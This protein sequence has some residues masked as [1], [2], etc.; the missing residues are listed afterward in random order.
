MGTEFTLVNLDFLTNENTEVVVI[1]PFFLEL[2][3]VG[4]LESAGFVIRTNDMSVTC[5][6]SVGETVSG[7]GVIGRRSIVTVLTLVTSFVTQFGLHSKPFSELITNI[8]LQRIFVVHFLAV[9]MVDGSDRVVERTKRLVVVQSGYL[10]LCK[11]LDRRISD[12]VTNAALGLRAGILRRIGTR[13]PN[14]SVGI[15]G[16]EAD[17]QVLNRFELRLEV[18]VITVVIRAVHDTFI[19]DAGIGEREVSQFVTA[20]EGE[21]MIAGQTM[22]TKGL[23]LPIGHF[24]GMPIVL[25][26]GNS[27][28]LV[29]VERLRIARVEIL[30]EVRRDIGGIAFRLMM[31]ILILHQ[32]EIIH[33][34]H[35]VFLSHLLPTH[36]AGIVKMELHLIVRV[37]VRIL[38]R[39]DDNTVS[40]LCTIDSGCG[41]ILENVHRLDVVRRDIRDRA[42]LE[43][44]NDVQRVAGLGK[45][46][47]T[48]NTDF[49]IRIGATFRRCDRYT[50]QFTLQCLGS[51]SHGN[52]LQLVCINRRNSGD[53]VTLLSR[54]ITGNDNFV[55]HLAVLRQHNIHHITSD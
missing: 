26:L 38:G 8:A 33:I 40:A 35:I 48:T 49:D 20:A 23:I 17:S 30:V 45:G 24:L 25:Y 46:C 18:Q 47:T 55:K 15:T 50:G 39:D 2:K 37:G 10:V 19:I 6:S 7:T 28:H 16:C 43:T 42:Y 52:V 12:G 29:L 21:A 54:T 11:Q 41:C 13:T 1:A 3:C 31:R 27:H 51:R 53:K 34:E 22:M 32:N 36:I 9:V 14:G 44:I 5:T 4:V